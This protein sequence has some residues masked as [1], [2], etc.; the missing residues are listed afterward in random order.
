MSILLILRHSRTAVTMEIY[1]EVPAAPHARR[2]GSSD[3]ARGRTDMS[4]AA[5]LMA[6]RHRSQD[7]N[8]PLS[9]ALGGTRTPNLL[10][11]S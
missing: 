9:C 5:A 10:I 6:M 1:T 11:R 7:R 8:R 2:S 4:A 3:R